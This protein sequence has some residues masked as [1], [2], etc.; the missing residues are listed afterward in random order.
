LG[1]SIYSSPFFSRNQKK[2]NEMSATAPNIG[3]AALPW[4]ELHHLALATCDLEATIRFYSDVLGMHAADIRPANPI[5]GRTC[6]IKPSPNATSELHFFEQADAQP[7]QLHPEMLQ[8]LMFPTSGLHHIAFALPD[9][10]AGKRLQERLQVAGIPTTPVMDQG[11]VYNLLFH[12][13]NDLLLEAN[14]PKQ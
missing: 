1:G 13:N 14:W 4:R 9:A 5:H 3:T 2:E 7:I 12:D 8:R 10:A 6:T 11:D